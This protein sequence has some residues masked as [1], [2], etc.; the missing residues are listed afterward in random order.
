M[1]PITWSV[2]P[3]PLIVQN[4]A[5]Y[6]GD[7]NIHVRIQK[8]VIAFMYILTWLWG[9][10]FPKLLTDCKLAEEEMDRHAK[11]GKKSFEFNSCQ[12]KPWNRTGF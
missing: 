2:F 10:E 9:S 12:F 5:F 6:D 3:K 11:H 7:N 4:E 1:L 8:S